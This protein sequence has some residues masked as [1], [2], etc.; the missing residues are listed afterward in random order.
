MWSTPEEAEEEGGDVAGTAAERVGAGGDAPP[1][2][3]PA[4]GHAPP[5]APAPGLAPRDVR[6]ATAQI[7]PFESYANQALF[8]AKAHLLLPPH[9]FLLL[10]LLLLLPAPDLPAIAAPP[11]ATE[12]VLARPTLWS[13]AQQRAARR[14]AAMA[15]GGTLLHPEKVRRLLAGAYTRS[16]QS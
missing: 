16:P 15:G 5:P 4:P 6:A 11:L 2:P 13:Q 12:R 3:A 10:L 1:P 14:G 8:G 7:I 9:S